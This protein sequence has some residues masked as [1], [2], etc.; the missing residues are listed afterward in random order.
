VNGDEILIEWN[1]TVSEIVEGYQI[2]ISSENFSDITNATLVGD[3]VSTTRFVV[4]KEMFGSL[5]NTSGWYI[6]VTPFDNENVKQAVETVELSA[7]QAPVSSDGSESDLSLQTLLSTPNLLVGGVVLAVLSLLVAFSRRRKGRSDISDAWDAQALTWGADE[8]S[9]LDGLVAQGLPLPQG[10]NPESMPTPGGAMM[11]QMPLGKPSYN[12]PRPIQPGQI[13][14]MQPVSTPPVQ[15]IQSGQIPPMQPVSTP[16]VQPI[17]PAQLQPAFTPP[18]Q[19]I[20][21]AQLQPAFIPPVQPIQPPRLQPADNPPSPQPRQVQP[22]ANIDV[23][24]LDEL[25]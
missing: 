20:E 14:P 9:S 25:L 22:S 7:N 13:P 3:D 2:H 21:P 1:Q 15:P 8:A 24:F 6:S 16:P 23:S 4:T 11:P 18:V 12:P 19:P 10:F 17:Q 5:T